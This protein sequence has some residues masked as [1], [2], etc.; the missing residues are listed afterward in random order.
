MRA[1]STHAVFPQPVY[2]CE[3]TRDITTEEY[4]FF[5]QAKS[6]SHINIGNWVSDDEDILDSAEMAD[7]KSSIMSAISEYSQKIAGY[8]SDMQLCITQSWLNWT[9]AGEFHH[10]HFHYNSLISGVLYIDVDEN[11]DS[12]T[13]HR[14]EHS[15]LQPI[16]QS[17]NQFNSP[18]YTIKIHR[19]MLVLFPSELSHSVEVKDGDNV[20]VSL[21]FN[22]FFRGTMGGARTKLTI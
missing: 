16:Y 9:T 19:G 14:R 17:F 18:D 8:Q 7:I 3:L 4:K 21:A 10:R 6:R 2:V 1:I 11:L 13:F 22:T 15:Q 20:R 5:S 12:I